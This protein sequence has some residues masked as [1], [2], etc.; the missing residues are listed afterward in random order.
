MCL[1]SDGRNCSSLK[2]RTLSLDCTL[3]SLIGDRLLLESSCMTSSVNVPLCRLCVRE[4]VPYLVAVAV[5][6]SNQGLS[7]LFDVVLAYWN[8]WAWHRIKDIARLPRLLGKELKDGEV[9]SIGE[10]VPIGMKDIGARHPTAPCHQKGHM[11]VKGPFMDAIR[12]QGI[13][14]T[15]LLMDLQLSQSI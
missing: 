15:D 12:Q 8:F 2:L 5:F 3:A 7:C 11:M 10:P 6:F 4:C 9:I 13:A 1:V 14:I